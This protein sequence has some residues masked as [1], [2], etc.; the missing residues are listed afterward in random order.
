MLYFDDESTLLP[1][2][3]NMIVRSAA[4]EARPGRGDQV[5]QAGS[6]ACPGG[7]R[8]GLRAFPLPH[9]AICQK[10]RENSPRDTKVRTMHTCAQPD[11]SCHPHGSLRDPSVCGDK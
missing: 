5:W 3:P 9:P 1:D 2:V 10:Q 4:H 6:A 7:A 8:A 11:A